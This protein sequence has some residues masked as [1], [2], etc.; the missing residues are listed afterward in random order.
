MNFFKNLIKKIKN[1]DKAVIIISVI[2]FAVVLVCTVLLIIFE[3]FPYIAYVFYALSAALL[4]Y[5]IYLIVLGCK[6]LKPRVIAAC[7]KRKVTGRFVHDYGFRTMVF[8][9]C[10]LII[11]VANALFNGVFGVVYLS[12]WNVAL[13][14]YYLILSSMRASVV[15]SDKRLKG[16]RTELQAL[17]IYCITGVLLI[18]LTLALNVVLWLVTAFGY[19]F[20]Y[21]DLLI[22]VA[23]L[24]TVYKVSMSVYNLVKVRAVPDYSVRAVRNINF[25]DALVSLLALQTA[26][27]TAFSE[28]GNDYT[29]W[30]AALGG[31]VCAATLAMGIY[32]IIKAVRNI[33]KSKALESGVSQALK[34]DEQAAHE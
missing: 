8:A 13:A 16:G 23:A 25:A 24:Y 30:N 15:F 27:L 7:E 19:G 1:P 6:R 17:K 26:M 11:S 9:V 18:V 12:Y 32:M 3:V 33:K 14:L 28:E 2:L 20:E 34:A 31:A 10:A 4:G 22:Y 5:M 21:R 29:S